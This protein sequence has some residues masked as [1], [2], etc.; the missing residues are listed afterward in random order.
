[1]T[2]G[3]VPIRERLLLP[4]RGASLTHVLEAKRQF[5]AGTEAQ[6]YLYDA[7]DNVLAFWP[8]AVDGH[9]ITIDIGAEDLERIPNRCDF[10]IFVVYPDSPDK[11]RPWYEGAALRM[12]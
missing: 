1:M 9:E 12:V 4:R 2:I 8:L 7:D 3:H 10:T 5:P 11:R 6:L